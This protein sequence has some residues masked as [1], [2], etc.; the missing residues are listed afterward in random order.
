MVPL[1]IAGDMDPVTIW[2]IRRLIAHHHADLLCVHTTKEL[3]VGGLAASLPHLP[4]VV[5]REVDLPLKNTRLNKYCY[6]RVASAVM[7]NSFATLNTLLAS[8]PWLG[9]DHITVV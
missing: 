1:R 4:I 9:R 2:K 3:R 7:V 6:T 8:A 5:S